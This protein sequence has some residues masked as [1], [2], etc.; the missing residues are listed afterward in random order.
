MRYKTDNDATPTPDS[1]D[2]IA[3][4]AHESE[5][6]GFVQVNVLTDNY[7]NVLNLLLR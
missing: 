3:M 2:G 7:W 1:V 4:Q 6:G 5:F